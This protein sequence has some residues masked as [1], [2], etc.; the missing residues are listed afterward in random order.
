MMPTMP[1]DDEV[2]LLEIP[3]MTP[4]PSPPILCPIEPVFIFQ[5]PVVPP[6]VFR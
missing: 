6:A 1:P 5:K 4:V 2:I 3:V